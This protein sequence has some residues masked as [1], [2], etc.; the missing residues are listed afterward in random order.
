M[1]ALV[2]GIDD[3]PSSPLGGCV[4]DAK[5][6]G[7][8][9]ETNEDNSPNFD[10]K[11][12]INIQTKAEL[13][14]S[15]KDLFSGE[16]DI[17]LLYFSGHGLVND[18]GGYIVTPDAEAY[19]EG[20]SM[21][22]ILVIANNSKAKNKVIILDCCFSGSFGSPAIDGGHVAKIGKGVSILTAS[23]DDEI[24]KEVNGQGVFTNL[25]LEA[26]RGGAADISGDITPGGVYA[27]I[28]QALGL[29]FQ[30]PVFKTNISRFITLRKVTPQVPR[31]ILRK[32]AEYFESP[33]YEY[34][35]DP[36]YED[37]NAKN[38]E[39]EVVE[40]YADPKNTAIFKHLQKLQSIGFVVPVDEQFMYF[41]AMKSKSCKLT[42]LG[43]HYWELANDK[44]I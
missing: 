17:A 32:V 10:V 28:D 31:D 40:P 23:R 8:I 22:E 18:I 2:I 27:F 11:L 20:V 3:Y 30:R 7:E 43:Q 21:D 33:E 16:S 25:L 15:I 37:T 44:K 24:S 36:S 9:I 38:I 19:D 29:W 26:L 6:F 34:S 13:R 14:K 39:H 41:A 35:L 5:M 4:N 42:P 12:E 1:K